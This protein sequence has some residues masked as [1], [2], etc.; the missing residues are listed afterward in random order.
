M[1]QS[2]SIDFYQSTLTYIDEWY[3]PEFL[4][5]NSSWFELKTRKIK[6]SDVLA[7][8]VEMNLSED[9]QSL[10]FDE[11]SQLNDV[12]AKIEESD[13]NL[14]CEEKWKNILATGN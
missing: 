2:L 7:L 9:L 4:P 8:A 10:L 13:F 11:T 14:T 6:H 3:R 12:L 1:Y 5:K